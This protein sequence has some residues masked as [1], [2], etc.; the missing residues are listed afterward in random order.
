MCM[1]NKINIRKIDPIE[2][3]LS[4]A[5]DRLLDWTSEELI[6]QDDNEILVQVWDKF[7][8]LPLNL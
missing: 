8:K 1:G 3:E 5:F 4:E 6:Y 2:Q 7:D